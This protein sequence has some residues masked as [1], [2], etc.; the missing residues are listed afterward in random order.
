[1]SM[2]HLL[3]VVEMLNQYWCGIAILPYMD[4][5]DVAIAEQSGSA[6]RSDAEL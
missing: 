5:S 1:M 3:S 6:P 4:S 2:K